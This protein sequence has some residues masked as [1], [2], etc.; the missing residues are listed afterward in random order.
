MESL[1]G[2]AGGIAHDFNNLLAVIIGNCALAK[3]KPKIAADKI[4]P[5]ETAA[6]RAAELCQQMLTYAGKANFTRSPIQLS[7]LVADMVKMSRSTIGQNVEISSDL[8]ADIP[9]VSVDASQLRQVTMNLIINAA[10]AIGEAQ[11]E[12]LVSLA[13]N[14]IRADQRETDYLGAFIPPGEYV[15]LEVTDNGCG[16][17]DE[18]QRR[19][20]EP[21]YTTK[22]AGRGL[23]ISVVLGIIKGHKGALQLFSQPGQGTTFKVFLPVQ[24]HKPAA[25]Q[26]IPQPAL[27]ESWQGK[28]TV[29]LVEDEEQ[30]ICIAEEMLEDLG[31]TV[32]KAANG[33]EAL[34]LYQQHAEAITLVVTDIGMPVMDGYALCRELNR[35]NS[36]LPIIISSGFGDRA[37]SSRI[38]AEDIAGLVNKPYDFDQLRIA[39]KNVVEKVRG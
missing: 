1:G 9:L 39:L 33:Q 8:A 18:T 22:F 24:I 11:G 25:D 14:T 12:V 7:E 2:L 19:I 37:I 17:D 32:I 4:P 36:K 3:L 28:G 27:P 26:T 35:L 23:G 16:M 5:I 34:D 6:K 30:V 29:L 13:K 10:E 38:A 15:C 21:F 20:F 31:F